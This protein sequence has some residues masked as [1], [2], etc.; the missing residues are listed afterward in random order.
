MK[1]KSFCA[2]GLIFWLIAFSTIFSFAVERWMTPAVV[3]VG[4][5][6]SGLLPA[7]CL[8]WEEDGPH[9]YQIE[10]GSNWSSGT[11][12]REVPPDS[13]QATEEGI[14]PDFGYGLKFVQ[15][16]TKPILEGGLVTAETGKEPAAPDLWLLFPQDGGTPKLHPVESAAFPFMEGRVREELEAETVYSLSETWD[17]FNALPLLAVAPAGVLFCLILWAVI[18]V[19]ARS[20][21]NNRRKILLNAGISVAFLALLPLLF[22]WVRLPSSLLPRANL[23]DLSHYQAEFSEIFTALAAFAETG[24]AT[25]QALLRH[26]S[27]MGWAALGVLLAGAVLGGAVAL[28]ELHRRT[29]REKFVPHHAAPRR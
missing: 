28:L 19:L 1:R 11:R 9:L 12:A 15:Y 17:F 23:L 26:A 14:K 6:M 25:A 18:C 27:A 22:A 2:F 13:Y 7:D 3:A 16:T 5:N 20:P 10:E 24:D 8:Q 4:T 29:R 21:R